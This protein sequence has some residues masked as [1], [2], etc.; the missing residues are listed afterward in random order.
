MAPMAD[1]DE[2]SAA[3]LKALVIELLGEVSALKQVVAAQRAEIARLKGP[4]SL[5]SRGMEQ[6]SEAKPPAGGGR[7]QG[8]GRRGCG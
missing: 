3:A 1:L 2:L 4:P 8:R 7:R 6:A 5:R